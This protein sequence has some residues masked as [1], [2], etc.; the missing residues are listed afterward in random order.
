MNCH[1]VSSGVTQIPLT[2][3]LANT[4]FYLFE[5]GYPSL[6]YKRRGIWLGDMSSVGCSPVLR[7]RIFSN[8]ALVGGTMCVRAWPH[9]FDADAPDRR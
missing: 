6:A 1:R 4:M 7:C 9:A 5:A 3:A 2:L 8:L